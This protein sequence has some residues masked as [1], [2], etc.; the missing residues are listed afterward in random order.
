[1]GA[2][3]SAKEAVVAP[4]E[5]SKEV[6]VVAEP[7]VEIVE[8][9]FRPSGYI[10][11]E[12]RAFGNTEGHTDEIV[13]D[14]SNEASD[15]Q[16]SWNRGQNNY[17]RLE[18]SFAIQATERFK[19][20]GRVRD[21]NNLDRN[22]ETSAT[23]SSKS[24]ATETRLRFSYK[25]ND[26]ITSRFQYRDEEDNS[27]NFEYRAI[28]NAYTNKGGLLS[29]VSLQPYLYHVQPVEN[30]GDYLNRVG[31]QV[32]FLGDLFAGFNYEFNTYLEETFLNH[33][34]QTG[35]DNYE[36]KEWTASFELYLYN[37][38][39][40]YSNENT[41]LDFNFTAG[42]DPYSFSQYAPYNVK[43]NKKGDKSSYEAQLVLDVTATHQLTPSLSVNAGVGAEY[44]NW[45]NIA[46]SS[47]QEWRW[48]PFAFAGMKAK[49]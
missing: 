21:F 49:F 44:R 23:K 10:G 18:T 32:Q 39:G 45:N 7:V 35:K 27:Q 48:Q 15:N 36:D 17:S 46:Q 13:K 16:N 20:E 29:K 33:D 2:T 4:V 30:G 14:S 38:I 1:V 5:V 11:L 37:T 22:D 3:V 34:F 26:V 9:A 47:A 12:Y 31:A 40:L 28:L 25:H 24:E 43:E 6:V 41:N 42:L 19:F 8:E